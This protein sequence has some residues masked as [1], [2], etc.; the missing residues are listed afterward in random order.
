MARIHPDGWRQLPASGALARELETLATLAEGLP[1]DHT[2]YHG[3]HWT[4]VNRDHAVFGEIDFIVVGPSGRLLLIE[5][6]SGFLDETPEGLVKTYSKTKKNVSVQMA[7]SADHLRERLGV[8]LKGH[9]PRLDVL[10]YCPDYTVRQPGSAGLDPARIVDAT[11]RPHLVA[12][13]QSLLRDELRDRVV[14]DNIERFLVDQLELVPEVNAVVGQAEALYT[15]LA[16]GLAEW[17]RRIEMT[18]FRLRVTGTAGSGKTQLAMAVFRDALAAGRRP[19]YVCYNRPLADH[20]ALIAP[21]G[22]EIATYHQLCDRVLRAHGQAPDF[23][24]PDAFAR[25]EEAF[26]A[27]DPGDAWHFDEL[28]VDEGQDFREEWRDAL[29]RLLRPEGRAWWLEDPMQNLYGRAPVDLPGW[30][31]ITSGRNYRSPADIVAALNRMLPLAEP[32]EAGSPLVG[33]EVEFLVWKDA[34]QLVEETKRAMT[35]AIGLGFR[36]EMIATITFRGREHSRFTPYD[37]LGAHRLKAFT[38][39]YDLLGNPVYSDGDF[40]IDSVYRFKGQAAPCV[41]FTEIDFETLDELTVRKLFVGATRASMKLIL[42]L[43]E[44][45]AAQLTAALDD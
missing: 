26:R 43:S 13:V 5:Q 2:V 25:L 17:A 1:D 28:I 6:K 45:A 35:R 44:R 36:R 10:L 20:I 38:G 39:R 21:P 9:Q 31:R 18:P 22:G 7:R 40:L 32:V 33:S 27:L 8:F 3:V 12:I 42:V 29:L 19:L 30:V 34:A 4:R 15:R 14:L 37:R 23:G 41:I 24:R 11:R 16:G